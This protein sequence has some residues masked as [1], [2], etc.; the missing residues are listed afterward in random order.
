MLHS[1]RCNSIY[2]T[3]YIIISCFFP[4]GCPWG[5]GGGK[6]WIPL[7]HKHSHGVL[8]S[9]NITRSLGT[10]RPYIKVLVKN[11][12][13]KISTQFMGS[14]MNKKRLYWLY[15]TCAGWFKCF[16]AKKPTI[17]QVN[18]T[19]APLISLT[20]RSTINDPL[21][22]VMFSTSQQCHAVNHQPPEADVQGRC[23]TLP[24]RPANDLE[25][26]VWFFVGKMP[27]I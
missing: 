18:M 26:W 20:Q 27:Q 13:S 12:P 21:R 23:H 10:C 5:G 8:E 25:V 22:R 2:S 11:L 17:T 19:Q 16:Y 1:H 4:W 9:R 7:I 3:Q 24:G 15:C 6:G 14:C